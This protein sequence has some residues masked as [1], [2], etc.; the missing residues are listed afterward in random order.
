MKIFATT[1]GEFRVTGG[2][3]RAT[4]GEFRATGGGFRATKGEFRATE[5]K[6]SPP[7]VSSGPPECYLN[8]PLHT[9]FLGRV[10]DISISRTILRI[11][12][13]DL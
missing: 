5:R 1:K 13:I 4:K 6:S 12:R 8:V 9:T 10:K 11:H 7:R 3:F 2:G